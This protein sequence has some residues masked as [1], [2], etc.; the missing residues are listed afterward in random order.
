MMNIIVA[1]AFDAVYT[2]VGTSARALAGQDAGKVACTVADEGHHLSVQRCQYQFADFTFRYGFAGFRANDFDQVAIFP[3]VHAV[4]FGALEGYAGT[5]HFSH[6]KAV[7]GFDAKHAFNLSALL[8]CVGF[9]T[10]NKRFQTCAGGV[11]PF[12]LEYLCQADGIAGNGM[13][14]SGLEVGDELI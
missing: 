7:I 2:D 12:F 9:G 1:T 4:L 6:T 10:D 14:G 3:E 11:H 13:Q 8:V 5:V